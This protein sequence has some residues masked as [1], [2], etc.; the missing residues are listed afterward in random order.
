ML[1]QKI[2]PGWMNKCNLLRFL[3]MP[4]L[5]SCPLAHALLFLMAFHVFSSPWC[6]YSFTCS[7]S[8]CWAHCFL[9]CSSLVLQLLCLTQ[10]RLSLNILGRTHGPMAPFPQSM[11]CGGLLA[12]S[13]VTHRQAPSPV[14]P[15]DTQLWPR[16]RGDLGQEGVII[17]ER[18]VEAR[19]GRMT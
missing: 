7:L 6:S 5:E 14:G 13:S 18:G 19:K 9:F 15:V 1:A 17:P 11:G 2:I 4:N 16:F 10:S 3:L 12:C 8:P